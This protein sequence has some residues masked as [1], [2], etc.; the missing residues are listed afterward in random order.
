MKSVHL[1][2]AVLM[3]LAGLSTAQIVHLPDNVPS[4]GGANTIPYRDS[5]WGI[6]GYTSL[7]VYPAAELANHG[8]TAGAV[9]V[10]LAMSPTTATG[11]AGTIT[12]PLGQVYFGHLAVS[13]PV[14]GQWLNN[15]A[16]TVT[17]WDTAVDG[18]LT[19]AWTADTWA[20]HPISCQGGSFIWDGVSDV[21]FYQTHAGTSNGGG[22][23]GGF[24]VHTSPA[25]AYIRHGLSNYNPTPGTAPTTTGTLGMRMR[26]TFASTAC[27]MLSAVTGG[28]GAG[29]LTLSLQHPPAGMVEGYTFFTAAPQGAVGTGPFFGIWADGTTWSIVSVPI[30]AGNPLHFLAGVPG[31][32]PD[33]PFSV[34]PGTPSFLAGQTWDAVVVALGAGQGYLSNT[35]AVRLNW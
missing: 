33:A 2:L 7:H 12:I 21:A 15:L 28:A 24:S 30:G 1:A 3:L 22:W 31:L 6:N 26:L 14:A 35:N 23:T 11:A 32:Y 20:S 16:G 5:S 10:G 29:D 4:T 13:P 19:F 18:P 34:P 17:L 27:Y 9:L 8:V 25:S